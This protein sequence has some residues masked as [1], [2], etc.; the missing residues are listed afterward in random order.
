ML[1]QASGAAIALRQGEWMMCRARSGETAPELGARLD[2]QSGLSGEC[3]RS[4]QVL[5]CDDTENDARVN[6][7]VCRYLGIR[8]IAVLPIRAGQETLGVLE[9]FAQHP[10]AFTGNEVASLESMCDLVISIVRPGPARNPLQAAVAAALAARA[11]EGNQVQMRAAAAPLYDPGDDLLCEIE[12]RAQPKESPLPAHA[13]KV[14]EGG[15]GRESGPPLPAAPPFQNPDPDDDMLCELEMRRDERFAPAAFEP[16]HAHPFSAFSPAPVH[17]AERPIS[18]K[19]IAA[20]VIVVLAGLL[21]LGWCNHAQGA[22]AN[23]A[24]SGATSQESLAGLPASAANEDVCGEDPVCL[25]RGAAEAGDTNAQ[26]ALAVRY[27]NGDGVWQSYP[28]AL[29]WFT[30]AREQGVKVLQGPAAEAWK[31]VRRW[32]YSIQAQK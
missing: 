5:V 27:A 4:G 6:L 13:F 3:V 19:L 7:D 15:R 17:P 26:L 1:T 18:R 11:A 14:V 10:A 9:V 12:L 25:L 28:E 16:E 31:R 21:W 22:A 20:G 23:P 32:A 8:S 29:K 24:V 30:R 2:T